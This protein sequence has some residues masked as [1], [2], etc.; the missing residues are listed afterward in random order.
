M[1]HFKE[2]THTH[3][4]INTR[5]R[6]HSSVCAIKAKKKCF[7]TDKHTHLFSLPLSLSVNKYFILNYSIHEAHYLHLIIYKRAEFAWSVHLSFQN[8][9][10]QYIFGLEVICWGS[11]VLPDQVVFDLT[12]VGDVKQSCAFKQT[13]TNN[14]HTHTHTFSLS[15][16]SLR[17]NLRISD[18]EN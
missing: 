13:N 16:S 8:R 17:L 5:T 2:H 7:L 10:I 18:S 9:V 6:T 15:I 12:V 4:H 14:K 1:C 3:T 11:G